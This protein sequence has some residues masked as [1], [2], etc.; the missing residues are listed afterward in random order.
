MKRVVLVA[1]L[2]LVLVIAA[3]SS[4]VFA[5]EQNPEIGKLQIADESVNPESDY[6]YI[7]KRMKEKFILMFLSFSVDKKANYYT[8]L[9]NVRL[10]E[11][12]HVVSNKDIANIQTSSQRYF[13]T[14]GQLEQ[15]LLKNNLSNT[16]GLAK[17]LFTSHISKLEVLRD[18]Y[19]Y[20]TSEYRF[21]QD[22]INYL[23]S[24]ISDLSF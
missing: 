6:N 17:D 22:D 24:Y 1:T 20:D 8:K 7:L 4:H 10:A 3:G 16:K 11:L 12:K 5:L 13:S 23:K 2:F 18:T 19:S 14:A 15:Y 9:V 21:I